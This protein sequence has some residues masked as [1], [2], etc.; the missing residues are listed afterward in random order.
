MREEGSMKLSRFR[1][2]QII[3][4]LNENE[5]G[6][7]VDDSSSLPWLP[8]PPHFQKVLGIDVGLSKIVA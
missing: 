3:A 7:K 8:V 5:A 2:E 1:E 4:M 6:A